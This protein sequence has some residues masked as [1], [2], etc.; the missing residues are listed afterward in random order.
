MKEGRKWFKLE[1]DI[2]T[3][4][5]DCGLVRGKFGLEALEVFHMPFLS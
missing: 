2:D 5:N 3:S 4:S 1:G